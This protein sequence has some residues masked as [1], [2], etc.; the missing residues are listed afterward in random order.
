MRRTAVAG[1]LLGLLAAIGVG[2]INTHT[3]ET[4]IIVMTILLAAG[5]MG[6]AW[7]RG[8]WRW[9]L[10]LGFSAPVSQLIAHFLELRV[11]YPNDLGDIAGSLVALIPASIGA[12][13]GAAVGWGARRLRGTPPTA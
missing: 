7:P 1:A 5:A 2:F 3:D 11:P 9:A 6:V 13:L 8:A 4:G 12:Y 10:L